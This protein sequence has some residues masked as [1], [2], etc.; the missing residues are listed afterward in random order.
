MSSFNPYQ[1]GIQWGNWGGDV[2]TNIIQALLMKKM[3]PDQQTTAPQPATMPLP[4]QSQMGQGAA[5]NFA[6][7][8]PSSSPAPVDY[9]KLLQIL[10]LL[11]RR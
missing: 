4:G 1:K 2:A 10:S 9:S 7:Q 11:G 8:A 6:A 5:Q 3:F